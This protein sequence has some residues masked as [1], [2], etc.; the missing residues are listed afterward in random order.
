M[1]KDFSWP[2][3]NDSISNQD[4][5]SLINFINEPNIRFTNGKKVEEFELEWSKWL[6][7]SF[8][9]FVFWVFCK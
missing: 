1:N 5:E 7:T 3:M 2:L 9:L 6:G 4:K 8:S